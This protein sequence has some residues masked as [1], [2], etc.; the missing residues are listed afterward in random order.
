MPC[1]QGGPWLAVH[2]ALH[3]MHHAPPLPRAPCCES[4][5]GVPC[6]AMSAD[7]YLYAACALT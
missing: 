7:G 5:A 2:V 6:T 1:W 3:H 4:S